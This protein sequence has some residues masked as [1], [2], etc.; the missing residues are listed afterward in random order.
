MAKT[1]TRKKKHPKPVCNKNEAIKSF[2]IR[3]NELCEMIDC[4]VM[5]HI[6]T[7]RDK[8][9]LA[10]TRVRIGNV[11][12]VISKGSI[13]A[14]KSLY[15][16]LLK[17]TFKSKIIY[18]E[19]LKTHISFIDCTYIE[20]LNTFVN[21]SKSI[22]PHLVDK[23]LAQLKIY[24]PQ[25]DQIVKHLF[26][27]LNLILFSE[28]FPDETICSFGF[29]VEK[30][31]YSERRYSSDLVFDLYLQHPIKEYILINGQRRPIY[32][33]FV[34]K[35]S[36]E[37]NNNISICSSKLKHLCKAEPTQMPVYI[38]SHAM[39]RLRERTSPIVECIIKQFFTITFLQLDEIDI[40]GQRIFIPLYVN[41][42]KIGYF[43]AELIDNKVIIKTFILIT[44]ASAPEG[45]K[46]QELTGFNKCD[47]SYWNIEKMDTFIFNEMS[48]NNPLYIYFEQSQLLPLFELDDSLLVPKNANKKEAHWEDMVKCVN[49][50]HQ[51]DTLS[52]QEL[53]EL[54][55][56]QLL[57]GAMQE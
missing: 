47:M 41:S 38:Q 43:I 20:A 12:H 21:G 37:P 50:Y 56:S 19:S 4:D 29:D 52:K 3:L 35:Y 9:I 53:N 44:H 24:R 2:L 28:N 45:H 10:C 31:K 25:E 30:D 48:A 36:G 16:K 1:K 55:H 11:R 13:N 51:R 8:Q 15:N 6:T 18:I 40:I 39:I 27:C 22:A 14:S 7:N 32:Q 57:S 17:L 46:F 23:Y 54:D 33:I 26:F 34:P 42:I 5:Q 49:K